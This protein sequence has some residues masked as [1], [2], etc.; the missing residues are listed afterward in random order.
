MIDCLKSKDKNLNIL[1]TKRAFKTKRKAFFINFK[2]I[3]VGRNC[4]RTESAPLRGM[5][6]PILNFPCNINF[7]LV[8]P[9]M[10]QI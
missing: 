7:C 9:Q 1:R 4:L 5:L 8:G 3:F 2:G 6:F 10:L